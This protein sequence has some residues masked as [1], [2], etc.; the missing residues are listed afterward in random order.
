MTDETGPAPFDAVILAG[1]RASDEL[2]RR[3]GTPLRA[4]FPYKGKPFIQW[5]YEAVRGCRLVGRIAVVGP[6]ELRDVP[7]VCEADLLVPEAESIEANL[8][9]AIARLLPEHRILVTASDNPLLTTDA[10]D[11]LLQRCPENAAVC[12]P[13]L[14]HQEFLRKF[15]RA[16]NTAVQLKDGS[17]IGG[18]CAVIHSR[19][20]PRL[21]HAIQAVL[22]AR[23]D[24]ARM[25]G[26][27][28]WQ[29][30]LK[31]KMKRVTS[32]DVEQRLCEITGLPIRFIRDCSPLFPIDVD[33]PED[34]IYLQRWTPARG[35]EESGVK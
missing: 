13:I 7:C 22:A 24:K 4:L 23:K 17:W 32:Q 15:P 30:A 9:G 12:Y 10:F 29:F 33:D 1:G 25:I 19:S 16:T 31:F 2:A 28:G 8:F 35:F 21:Q 18:G 20:V 6:D 11:N 26:L 34:W 3:T 5:V 14:R 27:L